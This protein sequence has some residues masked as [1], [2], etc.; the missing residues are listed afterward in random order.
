M[1]N[2][3][4]LN[5]MRMSN[6]FGQNP[7]PAAPFIRPQIPQAAPLQEMP[8]A[9]IPDEPM[10]YDPQ[11]D[12]DSFVPQTRMSQEFNENLNSRPNEDTYK[13]PLLRKILGIVAGTVEGYNKKSPAAGFDTAHGIINQPIHDKM[14]D[15]KSR[16][17]LL[18]KATQME[19]V[20]NRAAQTA[21]LS[22]VQ[23]KL[24]AQGQT[25]LRLKNE[26]GNKVAEAKLALANFIAN[27]PH[28]DMVKGD[29]FWMA[30]DTTTNK[31]ISTGI[32]TGLLTEA[33]AIAMRGKNALDVAKQHGANA[34]ATKGT[35]P[36]ENTKYT[37]KQDE[38]GQYV[39]IPT[40]PGGTISE[41]G[42]MGKPTGVNPQVPTQIQAALENA[43]IKAQIKYSG[44]FI[45]G[46]GIPKLKPPGFMGDSADVAAARK[47]IEDE[48]SKIGTSSVTNP[49]SKKLPDPGGLRGFIK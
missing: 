28:I 41:T 16:Q 44:A 23:K 37:I 46:A 5:F 29:K 34:V 19:D 6:V 4:F 39:L 11:A 32:P 8:V 45:K 33:E 9:D 42:A 2:P 21:K 27:K 17:D 43:A 30:H 40:T 3:N 26:R 48:I 24:L 10:P 15:W 35:A 25:D 18:T 36:G 38:T 1:V 20:N 49:T 22:E 7:S 12:L 13:A 31:L 14:E 47:M